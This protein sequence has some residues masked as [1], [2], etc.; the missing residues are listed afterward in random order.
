MKIHTS[1]RHSIYLHCDDAV[2]TLRGTLRG[3]LQNVFEA[4]DLIPRIKPSFLRVRGD[5]TH[6]AVS[7]RGNRTTYV[8]YDMKQG[9]IRRR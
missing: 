7:M 2:L 4:N 9:L 8:Y 3:L 6:E 5:M 1:K